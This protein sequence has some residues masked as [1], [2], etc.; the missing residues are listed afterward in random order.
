MQ[1]SRTPTLRYR[2]RTNTF[3]E[4]TAFPVKKIA[5]L[6]GVN[7]STLRRKRMVYGVTGDEDLSWTQISDTD[8][9]KIGNTSAKSRL[10]SISEISN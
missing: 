7:E 10:L 8:L 1:W 4:R 2:G 9:E 6:L 5:D 3:F